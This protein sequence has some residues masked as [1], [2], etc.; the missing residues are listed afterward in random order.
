MPPV[1][2]YPSRLTGSRSRGGPRARVNVRRRLKCGKLQSR[3]RPAE[4]AKVAWRLVFTVD[5]QDKA[6]AAVKD[7]LGANTRKANPAEVLSPEER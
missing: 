4:A 5:G 1:R 7:R 6:R 2:S 3:E